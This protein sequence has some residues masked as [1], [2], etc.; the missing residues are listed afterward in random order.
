[1]STVIFN[2]E[3]EEDI[4]PPESVAVTVMEYVPSSNS[5]SGVIAYDP[6]LLSAVVVT[7]TEIPFIN[8]VRVLPGSAI[9]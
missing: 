4:L 1:M 9:P 3:D 7:P 8:K 2:S 5:V 6:V